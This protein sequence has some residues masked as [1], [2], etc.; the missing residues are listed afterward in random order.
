MTDVVERLI[1]DALTGANDITVTIDDQELEFEV[2]F[3]YFISRIGERNL[4]NAV[5]VFDDL[6]FN[7]DG[8]QPTVLPVVN[9]LIKGMSSIGMD[10]IKP[11]ALPYIDSDEE[12]T[13][14]SI[15]AN[16]FGDMY[17]VLFTIIEQGHPLKGVRY[18]TAYRKGELVYP[19][20]DPSFTD[21]YPDES[22]HAQA[23]GIFIDTRERFFKMVRPELYVIDEKGVL[24]K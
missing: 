19:P 7:M 6:T 1:Q 4:I 20:Q 11:S 8:Y 15:L 3:N 12:E 23:R 22:V 21:S 17:W 16:E 2:W 18:A 10:F 14:G 13:L 5:Q 9:Q 24:L